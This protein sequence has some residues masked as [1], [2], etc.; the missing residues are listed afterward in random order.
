MRHTQDLE[1]KSNSTLQRNAR[2]SGTKS[3]DKSCAVSNMKILEPLG[4]EGGHEA[5]ELLSSEHHLDEGSL[6]SGEAVIP[7]HHGSSVS[8]AV[9]QEGQVLGHHVHEDVHKMV[10]VIKKVAVPY[11]VIK[12]IPYPVVK[13]IPYAVK[14]PVPQPYAV[15]KKVPYPVKVFVKVPFKVPKPVPVIKE[16]PYPV[17]V[18]V[19]RPVPVKVY[20]PDPY[21]V[22]KKVHYEVKV[23]VPEPFPIE[24][25]IPVPVKV[26]VHVSQPYPVE[27][28]VHYPLKIEVEQ[29][30]P[31]PVPKPYPVPVSK[32]VPY[33]V[34]RP[35]PVPVRVEVPRPVPVVVDKPVP[36]K[37]KVPVPVPYPV[38]KEVPYTVEKPVPVPVKVPVERPVPVHVTKPVAYPVEKPVPYPIKVPVALPSR[39]EEFGIES[40]AGNF[41]RGV[42]FY[43]FRKEG[44]EICT[45]WVLLVQDYQ[46]LEIDVYVRNMMRVLSRCEWAVLWSEKFRRIGVNYGIYE[47]II[48]EMYHIAEYCFVMFVEFINIIVLTDRRTSNYEKIINCNAIFLIMQLTSRKMHILKQ[49]QQTASR[50]DGILS[51]LVQVGT[52]RGYMMLNRS[53]HKTRVSNNVQYR[54][55]MKGVQLSRFLSLYFLIQIKSKECFLVLN[56]KGSK[57]LELYCTYIHLHRTFQTLQLHHG[58]KTLN[59]TTLTVTN[60]NMPTQVQR[61]LI[62]LWKRRKK[63]A[64]IKMFRRAILGNLIVIDE[65]QEKRPKDVSGLGHEQHREFCEGSSGH[66]VLRTKPRRLRGARSLSVLRLPIESCRL[67]SSVKLNE[68]GLQVRADMEKRHF[69]EFYLRYKLAESGE[70]LGQEAVNVP[71][72]RINKYLNDCSTE[73]ISLSVIIT[74]RLSY[75][76]RFFLWLAAHFTIQIIDIFYKSATSWTGESR[77]PYINNTRTPIRVDSVHL[78]LSSWLETSHHGTLVLQLL[79]SRAFEFFNFRDPSKNIPLKFEVYKK[80]D[81]IELFLYPRIITTSF[82]YQQRV[83]FLCL[84]MALLCSATRREDL[85]RAAELAVEK[86]AERAA[87]RAVEKALDS[88]NS[89]TETKTVRES[90]SSARKV[91][92]RESAYEGKVSDRYSPTED[93]GEQDEDAEDWT[94]YSRRSRRRNFRSRQGWSSKMDD[95]WKRYPR[96]GLHEGVSPWERPKVITIE[97]KVPV[98]VTVEQ[99]VP[100]P[101]YKH[102]PVEVKVPV[103]QPYTVEK[104]VPY[105]VKVFVNVPVEVPQPYVVEKQVPYEVKVDR[106][107]PYKVEVA[108]PQPYT[109]EKKVPVEVKVPVPQPYTVD[110]AVPYEVKV[111][112][113]VPEPY[114]VEKKVPVPVKVVVNR[115]Y[116]VPVPKPYA[117]EVTKPYPVP[118]D[119]PYPVKVKVP[120]DAPFPVPVER[121]IPV[122]VKVQRPQPYIVEKPVEVEVKKPYPVPVK[123]PV[124]KP[125]EVFVKKPVPVPVEKPFPYWV[126]VPVSVNQEWNVGEPEGFKDRNGSNEKK[127]S[128]VNDGDRK[129]NRPRRKLNHG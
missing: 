65:E 93:E 106:P 79:N 101:V 78:D 14:V 36:V 23:P 69:C 122:A 12:N 55:S 46:R 9:P 17:Q 45:S 62:R 64:R 74:W 94:K 54:A 38:E 21:P 86:A 82:N 109:V 107:V 110:K 49:L 59:V 30:I 34:D 61:F 41:N 84:L 42:H 124:D 28:V 108:V 52:A 128:E 105:P 66:T 76:K 35:V 15:E 71:F 5:D 116:P 77:P 100:Y 112:V 123:V 118:V 97:K 51:I 7:E 99:K 48:V 27:K 56:A 81:K 13:N 31:V 95:G 127:T 37:V 32:P 25:K 80:K 60:E 85:E 121:P 113:K 91:P 26:P 63:A 119:K 6:S 129:S 50:I 40:V 73:T 83:I 103:P 102:V 53:V 70:Y 19:D 2:G 126:Q 72:T 20:I 58:I 29:P 111:P 18:P 88:G 120:V 1:K 4:Y 87:E 47:E 24:R 75:F 114:E 117:V 8:S 11:P 96:S 16:V 3:T 10:T 92:Y 104:K 68:T 39:D 115:P 33:P 43:W 22:E 67:L 89:T 125:Y 44:G 57:G 98:P 90:H